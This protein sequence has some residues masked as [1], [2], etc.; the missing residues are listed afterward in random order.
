VDDSLSSAGVPPEDRPDDWSADWSADADDLAPW[1]DE[2]E[3]AAG[4]E[5]GYRPDPWD[6]EADGPEW[7]QCLPPE[8]RDEAAVRDLLSVL[9]GDDGDGT[10]A[11]RLSFANGGLGDTMAPGLALGQL[12]SEAGLDGYGSF[13]EDE[14]TGLLQA[15]SRQ[16]SWNQFLHAAAVHELSRRR[17]A[18]AEADNLS[19]LSESATTELAFALTLTAPAAGRLR[20]IAHGLQ[21]LPAVARLLQA[22]F[23]DWPRAV[24]FVD[25]LSYVSD[26]LARE[27]SERLGLKAPEWTAPRLRARL[28]RAVIT[29]DPA[30]A[31]RRKKAA[32][33][34][35][36]VEL[37]REQ[38]GN[39]SLA[40]RE[41]PADRA[42]AADQRV[43]AG[44]F[45]L[46]ENGVPGSKGQLRAL[47]YLT[48]LNGESIEELIDKPYLWPVNPEP[49]APQPPA[50]RPAAQPPAAGDGAPAAPSGPRPDS[51]PDRDDPGPSGTPPDPGPDPDDPGPA[52]PSDDGDDAGAYGDGGPVPAAPV[53]AGAAGAVP[54][55]LLPDGASGA[56]DAGPVPAG[57]AAAGRRAPNTAVTS[58]RPGSVNVIVPLSALAGGGSPGEV[59]GFGLVDAADS[60]A[61]VA[62]LAGDPATRWHLTVTDPA[63]M[64]VGHA[65][66]RTGPAAGEPVTGWVAGLAGQLELLEQE[67]CSHQRRSS[68]YQPSGSLRHLVQV[69][70]RTCA[71]PVCNRTSQ[72]CD[73]DHTIA[74]EKGGITCSCN[75]APLCRRD[76][77]AKQA[78]GFTLSQERPGVMRWR[79]GGREYVTAGEPYPI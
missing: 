20:D 10:D 31:E 26:D 17:I 69:R 52:A 58:R 64:A 37:R 42:L 6:D 68:G 43:E 35:A 22:G 77:H 53:P 19:F 54:A 11:A 13:G 4:D 41:L 56:A 27:I 9:P 70:Q 16:V 55:A 33:H 67:D 3:L 34:D 30:A 5:P 65:C 72:R 47:A 39:A 61:V 45:W 18:E 57:A 1:P 49:A 36:R 76:H 71:S 78:P 44:A 74:Y 14:L 15:T 46:A 7:P 75:L 62:G 50:P 8:L 29:A 23:L 51:G 21:R 66:A 12:I 59:A 60:R 38:S 73:L 63:G 32:R 48:Y 40:G 2:D 24:I 25:E 79:V 28:A